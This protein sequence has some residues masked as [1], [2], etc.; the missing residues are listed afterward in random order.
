MEPLGLP[1][2]VWVYVYANNA[3]NLENRRS[4]SVILIYVNNALIIFYIKRQNT[5]ESSSFGLDFVELR[6][7]TDMVEALMYKLGTFGVNLKG[8][9]EVY[10]DNKSVVTNSSALESFL[11]NIHNAICYHRVGEA[12]STGTL[13]VG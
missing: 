3:G 13:R 9:A 10:R 6:I 8:P 7:S 1:V 12:Q 4:H 5:V 11:N 2:T